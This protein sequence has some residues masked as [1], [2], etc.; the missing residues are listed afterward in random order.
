MENTIQLLTGQQA[1]KWLNLDYRTF[2]EEVKKGNIGFKPVGKSGRTKRYPLK[3]LQE[4]LNNTTY[5]SDYTSEAKFTT[6]TSR[7][8]PPMEPELTLAQLRD[9]YFPKK[10]RNGASN[11]SKN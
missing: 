6:L 7:S 3:A 8:L 11:I 5:H 10:Q 2:K 4:W 9:K 1:A